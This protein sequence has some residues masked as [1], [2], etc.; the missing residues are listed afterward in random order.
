MTQT[1][2]NTQ[3]KPTPAKREIDWTQYL[4]FT[5]FLESEESLNVIQ[6]PSQEDLY[7]KLFISL[8]SQS[9]FR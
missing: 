5:L 9:I 8:L 1:Q 4:D 3:Y 7:S 6:E 2:I